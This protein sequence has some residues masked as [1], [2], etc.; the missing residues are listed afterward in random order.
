MNELDSYKWR[1]ATKKFDP[2]KKVSK[3][4]IEVIKKAISLAPSSYGLQLFKVLIIENQAI[5][6]KLRKVSYNQSQISDA[7]HIFVFCNSIKIIENDIDIYLKNK[8]LIQEKKI[9]E[10]Q[11]YG[12]FLKKNLLNKDQKDITI[13]TSNQVYIALSYLMTICASMKLDTCPIEGFESEKYNSILN[14]NETNFSSSVVAAVG[15]RS[16]DDLSQHDK[17]V[18]KSFD[19]L[20]ETI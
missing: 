15:Y 14:L 1:Y 10:I 19:Q 16:K 4:K 9:S 7:S 6:D 12:D 13:W 2:F 18:R 17:K 3:T 20:F 8:S 11:G 5:K